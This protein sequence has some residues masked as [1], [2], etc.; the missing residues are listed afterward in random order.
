[1]LR[2]ERLILRP[3][4]AE[5]LPVFAA[6]NADP[7]VMKYLGGHALT[8]AQ[9]DAMAQDITRASEATGYGKLAVE[10]ASDGVFLGMCGLS[11]E[12]WYPDDL[13]IGWRLARPHW[14]QGYA[15]EAAWAWMAY[16]FKQLRLNRIISIADVPNARSIAVMKR[17]G[18]T[19]DHDAELA[20]GE[21]TFAATIYAIGAGAFDADGG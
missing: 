13:E 12:S 19:W 2:T 20:D 3:F 21:E 16:G 7:E 4:R 17:L 5:D 18:M 10:R 1:M 8:R 6:M 14:G 11:R 9:S 15:T